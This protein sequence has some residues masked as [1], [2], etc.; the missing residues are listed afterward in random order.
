MKQL[1]LF[2]SASDFAYGSLATTDPAQLDIAAAEQFQALK[3]DSR[4]YSL[5]RGYVN[6]QRLTFVRL[7]AVLA[8]SA[9]AET[10]AQKPAPAPVP[11]PATAP[12]E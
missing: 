11:T 7:S 4:D 6:A 12:K 5:W 1:E 2:K 9:Q 10:K 8:P 3:Y